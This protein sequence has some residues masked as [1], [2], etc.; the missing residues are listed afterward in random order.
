VDPTPGEIWQ[1]RE[2]R[3]QVRGSL[4]RVDAVRTKRTSP[5]PNG[6]QETAQ[7]VEYTDLETFQAYTIQVRW[8]L[9]TYRFKE[10]TP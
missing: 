3:F 9:V 4:V 5:N 8:F 7:W 1:W 6:P 10:V 2:A